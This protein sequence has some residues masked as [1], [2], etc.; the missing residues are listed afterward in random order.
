MKKLLY[1][2]LLSSFL[3]YSQSINQEQEFY[4]YAIKN[5][6]DFLEEAIEMKI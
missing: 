5:Y 6:Y 3:S 2:F 4:R 1:I